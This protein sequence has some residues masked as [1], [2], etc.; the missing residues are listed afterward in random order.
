MASISSFFQNSEASPRI[1]GTPL[2]LS[3]LSAVYSSRG[4]LPAKPADVLEAFV[5]DRFNSA[6]EDKGHRLEHREERA[7]LQPLALHMMEKHRTR[8]TSS[9]AA[10]VI[11][12]PVG[13]SGV[14][15]SEM[16]S[17]HSL[18]AETEAGVY[19]FA[20]RTFQEYLAAE[21]LRGLG[22]EIELVRHLPD[23]WWHET[24]RLYAGL[25]DASNL[26]LACLNAAE[27]SPE[28]LALA[29][30]CAVEARV[31][32]ESVLALVNNVIPGFREQNS[33]PGR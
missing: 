1:M 26:V 7:N 2:V 10:V 5:S 32:D 33:S 27:K 25:G 4:S 31:L 13:E 18:L 16:E 12:K 24:I 30:D 8:I 19:R 29:R 6:L 20:Q 17:G 21:H 14:M 22:K 28:T 3:M 11:G 9:E 15:L 23:P